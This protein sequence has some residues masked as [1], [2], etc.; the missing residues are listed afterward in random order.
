MPVDP[1]TITALAVGTAV[2]KGIASEAAKDA[3][4]LMKKAGKSTLDSIRRR[5]DGPALIQAERNVEQFDAVLTEVQVRDAEIL[6][7][8][9]L[10]VTDPALAIEDP[11]NFHAFKAS[12]YAASRTSSAERHRMLAEALSMRFRA[13]SGENNAVVITRAIEIM[14]TLGAGHL[15]VLG[16]LA[17]IY[18]V[19]SKDPARDAL[20][21][22]IADVFDRANAVYPRNKARLDSLT[23]D[24]RKV[25]VDAHNREGEQIMAE[26]RP[27]QEQ[28]G[29]IDAERSRQFVDALTLHSVAWRA[30][31][32]DVMYLNAAGCVNIERSVFRDLPAQFAD[33]E[34][35]G[36]HSAL[37]SNLT[38]ALRD[39]PLT[40]LEASWDRIL[41]H[42]ALT[43][44]GLVIGLMVHDMK[45]N[46]RYAQEWEWGSVVPWDRQKEG[47]NGRT[48]R[49]ITESIVQ[50]T[51]RSIHRDNR[52]R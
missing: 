22:A 9:G 25:A 16:L 38:M 5:L 6:T 51:K 13:G 42:C 8:R 1:D 27:L 49:E 10:P 45:A 33:D 21:A 41:Q 3:Y 50:E 34:H 32:Q 52:G 35:G 2:G 43:P 24:E 48:P 44:V 40:Q 37:A 17:C 30:D 46:T 47:W 31:D 36:G 26:A 11:D 15:E 7:D 19:R 12:A 20:S 29:V 28:L 18:G 14:P 39:E 23:G 4:S